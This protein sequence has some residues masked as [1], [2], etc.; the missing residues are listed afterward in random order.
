MKQLIEGL[1]DLKAAFLLRARRA[2]GP[3][4]DPIAYGA[5]L[6]AEICRKAA[7][8]L[9]RCVPME[10]EVEG[11]GHSWWYVCPERHVG[12]IR[13]QHFCQCCGQKLQWTEL[14]VN[15]NKEGS[16]ENAERDFSDGGYGD[17]D[18]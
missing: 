13:D 8:E 18:L 10:A 15:N 11:G 7:K 9:K 12:I 16:E 5:F 17:R 4:P 14:K 1:N 2:S 6:N 3:D